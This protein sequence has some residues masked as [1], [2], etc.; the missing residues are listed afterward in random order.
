MHFDLIS[1]GET[2]N[3]DDV[4]YK[5]LNVFA[6]EERY[7]YFISDP[8]HLLK[9]ARNSLYHS[10]AGRCTR[11]MWNQGNFLLWSHITDIFNEDR[12]CGLQLLP[13]LTY[14]H[15]KLSS[16]SVMN[17]KLAA[18]VLSS[19][20]GNV[21]LSFGSRESVGT[22]NYCLMIDKFFDIMNVRSTKE[23]IRDAKPFLTPF[24]SVDDHRFTWLTSTFLPYF[25]KWQ[26]SIASRPGNYDKTARGK[27]FISQQTYDGIKITTRSMIEL[28]KFLL[29]KGAQYVLTEKFSQDPLE[30]SKFR[31][32]ERYCYIF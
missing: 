26:S 21:L 4:V 9:T 7:I 31:T 23:H 3:T 29:S 5:T 8:P 25:D 1:D 27:M 14:E 19:T 6:D 2:N 16:Y 15:V 24:T 17:V 13:K 10:G 32:L 12:E 28:V 20:V 11:L 30:V 22:A 18:Q